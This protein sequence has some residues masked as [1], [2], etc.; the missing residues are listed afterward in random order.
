MVPPEVMAVAQALAAP[1]ML[2]PVYLVVPSTLPVQVLPDNVTSPVAANKDVC[3]TASAD[4]M[5]SFFMFI[6]F[7]AGW[8]FFCYGLPWLAGAF[9]SFTI[10]HHY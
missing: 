4:I 7:F 5:I 2:V 3:S 9:G 6:P 10:L 8:L 1:A